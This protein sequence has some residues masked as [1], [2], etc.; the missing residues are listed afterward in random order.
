M[1]RHLEI[2]QIRK[3]IRESR[4]FCESFTTEENKSRY[5]KS[6]AHIDKFLKDGVVV[7]SEMVFIPEY[8]KEKLL[9][10]RIEQKLA[11]QAFLRQRQAIIAFNDEPLSA[12]FVKLCNAYFFD[13]LT[14][15]S[16]SKDFKLSSTLF[17][18]S[19]I[20]LLYLFT[21]ILFPNKLNEVEPIF[22]KKLICKKV[23]RE[24]IF[25]ELNRRMP[26]SYGMDSVLY[27]AS[28]V[29]KEQKRGEITVEQML[30]C[31]RGKIV[32]SYLF[33]VEN[34]FSDNEDIVNKMIS[35]LADYHIQNSKTV[36]Y[37]LPFHTDKWIYFPIEILAILRIRELRG[38][39]NDF[40]SHALFD[41]FLP[42]YREKIELSDYTEQLFKKVFQIEIDKSS[43]YILV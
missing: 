26:G 5:A 30:S 32:P 31:C 12:N 6:E 11:E 27:L 21:I 9:N 15:I 35:D 16:T 2:K 37:T 34:M 24:N 7:F 29:A 18:E 40:I 43:E 38:L 28:W 25:R 22:I 14:L 20:S 4:K 8:G 36:D 23:E 3:V 13:I 33:A 1:V 42:F 19:D 10:T 17:T 39:N 41:I